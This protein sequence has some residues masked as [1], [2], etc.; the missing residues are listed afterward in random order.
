MLTLDFVTIEDSLAK[1]DNR[2]IVIPWRCFAA[3][4]RR[5]RTI[6]LVMCKGTTVTRLTIVR[7]LKV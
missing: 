4:V 3:G 6:V 1:V 7:G 5:D 2:L